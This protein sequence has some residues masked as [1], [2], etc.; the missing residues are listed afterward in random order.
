MWSYVRK[1]LLWMLVVLLA[2]SAVVFFAI[3]LT[4]GDPAQLLLGPQATPENLAKLR[5]DLG[6]DKPIVVQ[7]LI[8]LKKALAGNL[9]RSITYKQE[10]MPLVILKMKAS[11]ILGTAALLFSVPLGVV[12]GIIAGAKQN[13]LVDRMI[14]ILGLVGISLPVFWTSLVLIL[15]LSLNFQLFP[16][17]GMYSPSSGGF[18]DLLQHL[19]LPAI[20]LGLVPASVLA[21]ITR[22]AMLEV[23]HQD[24]VRTAR[25]KGHGPIAVTWR[26]AFPNALIPVV[27]VVGLEVGYV[28]GGAVV[29][30]TVFAWPG[31]GEAMMKAILSRD[32]PLVMGGTLLMASVF[33]ITNLL[34]DMLYAYL[35]PRIRY[36]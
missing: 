5:A 35:D 26:H 32:F 20:A 31:I 9:G 23:M 22:S 7:Y 10:V 16:A 1:R 11:G 34:V 24:Y 18:G 27:T 6:L 33:V 15:F 28:I 14:T 12:A 25:A 17:S 13:S 29:V 36:S 2:V 30:E 4:P 19:I 8:W 3:R 21:R